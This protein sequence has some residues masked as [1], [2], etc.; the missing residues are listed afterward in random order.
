MLEQKRAA[1][2][3]PVVRFG[4]KSP[5]PLDTTTTTTTTSGKWQHPMDNDQVEVTSLKTF[6]SF[7]PESRESFDLVF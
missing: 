5:L 4:Y 3:K 1:N 7:P 6:V 2:M